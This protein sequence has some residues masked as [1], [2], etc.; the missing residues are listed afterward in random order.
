MA[1]VCVCGR[2]EACFL[3]RSTRF[4]LMRQHMAVDPRSSAKCR[5]GHRFFSCSHP[6]NTIALLCPRP[7]VP[8]RL[9]RLHSSLESRSE[10]SSSS[11]EGREAPSATE[12]TQRWSRPSR[13]GVGALDDDDDEDNHDD[14]DS[15][16]DDDG[17]AAVDGWRWWR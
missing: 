6:P 17:D 16:G 15:D 7:L 10:R 13:C 11:S 8:H 3:L 2:S 5:C 1:S 12:P 14:G 4:R 9:V